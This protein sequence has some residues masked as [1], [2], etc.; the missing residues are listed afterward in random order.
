MTRSIAGLSRRIIAASRSDTI[1]IDLLACP[2]WGPESVVRPAWATWDIPSQ[3]YVIE[4]LRDG[5][6]CCAACGRRD[7]VRETMF[8]GRERI[9]DAALASIPRIRATL[10]HDTVRRPCPICALDDVRFAARATLDA[11]SGTWSI[12]SVDDGGHRC[13]TCGSVFDQ[14][15]K[16]QLPT[17]ERAEAVREL[18]RR[19]ELA[20]RERKVVEKLI[21]YLR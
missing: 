3:G 1:A 9:F 20:D 13:P 18:R 4:T 14:A 2:D 19:A 17:S 8:L 12:A 5:Q 11:L 6:A 21:G 10:A 7:L 15:D 16:I